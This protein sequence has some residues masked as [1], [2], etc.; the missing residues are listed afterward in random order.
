M[1]DDP[2]KEEGVVATREE[3]APKEDQSTTPSIPAEIL[4]KI[5]ESQRQRIESFVSMAMSAG[6]LHNPIVQ[7]VTSSH[8]EQ[9]IKAQARDSE[10]EYEDR[11]HSRKLLLGAFVFGS[12]L[13]TIV[14]IVL[15]A[16]G[17]SDILNELIKSGMIGIGGFGGGYGFAQ[18][19]RQKN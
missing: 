11:K 12:I 9:I 6:P 10:L 7:K 1:A 18:V 2:P 15:S 17:K 8:I 16:W 14:L 5:P 13:T 4:S 3:S 19:R